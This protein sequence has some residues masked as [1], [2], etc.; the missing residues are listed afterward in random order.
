[1]D[2]VEMAAQTD[3]LERAIRERLE[4]CDWRNPGERQVVYDGF[5]TSVGDRAA[6]LRDTGKTDQADAVERALR[7]AVERVERLIGNDEVVTKPMSGNGH[8]APAVRGVHA[9]DARQASPP[10]GTTAAVPRTQ[11]P[12]AR[13]A[14]AG[15][16]GL[17][18]W[19]MAAGL[20]AVL[21]LQAWQMLGADA[22]ARF[23]Y[24]AAAACGPESAKC[25][26]T[27]WQKVSNKQSSAYF[28]R[29]RLGHV[30]GAVTV[31]FSPNASGS[32]A[33]S[34]GT[35]LPNAPGGNPYTIEARPDMMLLHIWKGAPIH[36]VY[37]GSTE[38]FTSYT[39]GYFRVVAE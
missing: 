27:G 29:H 5:A 33:Y 25:F 1:M 20:V 19:L 2:A 23:G 16:S 30:P 37:D 36:S 18:T 22:M 34:V 39:E 7:L 9:D 28:Y 35:N 21:G 17:T 26:D 3:K 13:P 14:A 38:K 15:R 6:R 11:R 31:W 8:L 12:T 32:P 10:S 24:P 4:R